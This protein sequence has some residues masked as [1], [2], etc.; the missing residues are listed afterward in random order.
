MSQ[1]SG[2]LLGR[3]AHFRLDDVERKR[4]VLHPGQLTYTVDAE[5]RSMIGEMFKLMY[6]A[7]LKEGYSKKDAAKEA[8]ART[9]MSVVTGK[10]IN[11]QLS[12]TKES[13][14]SGSHTIFKKS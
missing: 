2:G 10:P 14:K 8:Q 4:S 12:E 9:G 3:H 1:K 13:Y 6:E 11:R 7:L 5:L